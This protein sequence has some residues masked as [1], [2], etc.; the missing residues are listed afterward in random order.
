VRQVPLFSSIDEYE[1][2]TIADA[3][4]VSVFFSPC[5]FQQKNTKSR[6]FWEDPIEDP[7]I[8]MN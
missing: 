2:M 4:K 5:F 8:S 3:M 1:L 6:D 7:E